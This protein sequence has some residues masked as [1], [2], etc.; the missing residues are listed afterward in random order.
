[1]KSQ[2]II[3]AALAASVAVSFSRS[4]GHC[5]DPDRKP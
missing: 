3:L 2:M 4:R 1:M 5:L